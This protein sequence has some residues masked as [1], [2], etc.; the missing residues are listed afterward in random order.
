MWMRQPG[1]RSDEYLV[2]LSQAGSVDAFEGLARRWTPRL[3]RYAARMLGGSADSAEAARDVVQ[4]NVAWRDP[5]AAESSRPVA[6]PGLDLRDCDSEVRRRNP[7]EHAPKAVRSRCGC[8]R[9]WTRSK[10]HAGSRNRFGDSD[11]WTRQAAKEE[12]RSIVKAWNDAFA[13]DAFFNELSR[14][15]QRSSATS[16]RSSRRASIRRARWLAARMR[17]TAS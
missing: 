2:V 14:R 12:L 1:A 13:L 9:E 15:A 4:E 11:S 6:V 3:I 7:R 10:S 17:S 16:A 8:W 5:R